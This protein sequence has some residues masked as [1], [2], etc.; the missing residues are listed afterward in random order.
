MFWS[1]RSGTLPQ[2]MY[3]CNPAFFKNG[4]HFY[5]SY[6]YSLT[7]NALLSAY[8]RSDFAPYFWLAIHAS[9]RSLSTSRGS[10]PESSNSS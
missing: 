1:G 3:L 7:G 10:A 4:R 5:L 8:S 6:R 2:N 9:I